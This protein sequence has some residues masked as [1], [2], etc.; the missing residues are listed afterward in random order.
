MK[1]RSEFGHLD[2]CAC[3]VLATACGQVDAA[4][5]VH[6]LQR[7]EE[8]SLDRRRGNVMPVHVLCSGW[9]KTVVERP[10][11]AGPDGQS[12]IIAMHLPGETVH[13][14]RGRR[15]QVSHIAVEP[16]VVRSMLLDARTTAEVWLR[17]WKDAAARI[18]RDTARIAALASQSPRERLAGFLMD[19]CRRNAPGAASL[20]LA[21]PL[22]RDDVA[23]YLGVTAETVSRAFSGLQKLGLVRRRGWSEIELLDAPG[24][25]RLA[26]QVEA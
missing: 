9:L 5:T 18:D 6:K 14:A 23:A 3:C 21:M 8:F 22:S 4:V 11:G 7:G 10:E 1:D 16:S 24:L 15:R 26:G 2:L 20:R 12:P 17:A 13:P 25:G 19:L